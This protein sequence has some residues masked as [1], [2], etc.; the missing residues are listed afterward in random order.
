MDLKEPI[1]PFLQMSVDKF[2]FH[3]TQHTRGEDTI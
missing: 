2:I 1:F 3:Q